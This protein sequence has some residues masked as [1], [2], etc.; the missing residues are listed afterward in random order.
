[1]SDARLHLTNSRRA[2]QILI[3]D[4]RRPEAAAPDGQSRTQP[5]I[6]DCFAI[7]A[8]AGDRAGLQEK[9][10]IRPQLSKGGEHK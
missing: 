2:Y 1:M 5:S 9:G 7:I 4:M 10:L 6:P 3:N 8:T